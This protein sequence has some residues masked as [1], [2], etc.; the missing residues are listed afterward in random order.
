MCRRPTR[1]ARTIKLISG[2]TARPAWA[3]SSISKLIEAR[4]S[5][6]S[7]HAHG[8]VAYEKYIGTKDLIHSCCLAH[9]R[10]GFIDALKVHSKGEAP[11]ARLER[12][13][14]PIDNLLAIDRK[15]QSKPSCQAA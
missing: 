9:A 1:N 6:G 11:Y 4:R 13:V 14:A 15:R 8:Y 7:F 12:V 3:W 10:C 5:P 2:S